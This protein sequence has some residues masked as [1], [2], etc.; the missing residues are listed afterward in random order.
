MTRYFPLVASAMLA[1]SLHAQQK[2]AP[3]DLAT[4][5]KQNYTA[6]KNKIIAAAEEMPD[7]GYSFQPTPEE[8]NFGG[9]VA[10]VAD[11]QARFCGAVCE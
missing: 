7:V 4:D 3:A 1:C 8:R 9:W 5:L 10:H 2:G 6:G 11:S